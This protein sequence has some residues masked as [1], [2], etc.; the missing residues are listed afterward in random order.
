MARKRCAMACVSL[1]PVNG[2]REL[3]EHAGYWSVSV[4]GNW[5]IIFRF[6]AGNACDVDFV[7]YH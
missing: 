1:L 3:T 2:E 7:D 5:R 6:D 4:P